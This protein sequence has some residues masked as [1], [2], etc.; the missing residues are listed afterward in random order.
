L[1]RVF[2]NN[3]SLYKLL[4]LLIL[5][6]IS[7]TTQK[8][9]P[10]VEVATQRVI[11]NAL[12]KG[13]YPM[14][15]V[16][17]PNQSVIC[18][19]LN[20]LRVSTSRDKVLDYRAQKLFVGSSILLFVEAQLQQRHSYYEIAEYLEAN[21]HL[22]EMLQLESISPAQLSRK[23]RQLP[24]EQLQ[25]VF[26]SLQSQIKELTQHKPG[27]SA[28]IGKLEL[29]DATEL[30]LPS[31]LS[32]WAYCS[33][34]NHGVKM[35]TSLVIVDKDTMYPHK[36]VAT[37]K[38]VADHEV[39]MHFTVDPDA[40]YVM[41]RGYQVYDHFQ[42]WTENRI[43]F[44]ARV[45]EKSR[46]PI[47]KEREL[48]KRKKGFVRDADVMLPNLS[49]KL[50][51]I[52][53]TDEKGRLYRLVTN[54]WDLSAHQ[55]AEVYKNRWQI[56]LFF[57]WVKQHIR[58]VKPHGYTVEAIWNQMY[59]ALIAYSLCLLIRLRLQCKQT[60]WQLLRLICIH[61]D[62]PWS[63]LMEALWRKPKRTSKGRPKRTGR[64][65]KVPRVSMKPKLILV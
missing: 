40:T 42:Y 8:K 47:V 30:T 15:N 22:Q 18:Q 43:K 53:F 14:D 56:E 54:R 23:M 20:L 10:I 32:K 52:E 33:R 17:I 62:H 21:K 44:V 24:T 7:W 60:M 39:A 64:P 3:F 29:L 4:F 65:P 37:T 59:I 49:T 5:D 58:L 45:K 46:L 55:I 50:R 48:P 19:C 2:H 34:S 61:A 57:K 9:S 25:N 26:L 36:I 28:K 12:N 63:S 27:L 1:H 35:H 31:I 16:T 13:D 11:H 38:D 51:L 6:G 41:D